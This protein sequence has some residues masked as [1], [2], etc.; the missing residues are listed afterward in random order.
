MVILPAHTLQTES[1][2][3]NKLR[4]FLTVLFLFSSS[5]CGAVQRS[6]E[7]Q[8]LINLNPT[9]DNLFNACL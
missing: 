9:H 6:E 2:L 7:D 5:R 8:K 4:K 1:I 3:Q